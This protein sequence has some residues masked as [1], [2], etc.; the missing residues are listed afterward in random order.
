MKAPKSVLFDAHYL[1]T[2]GMP[3]HIYFIP[4]VIKQASYRHFNW[5]FYFYY[6][7][8]AYLSVLGRGSSLQRMVSQQLFRLQ[9]AEEQDL[10][11]ADRLG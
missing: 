5:C 8:T 4:E 10:C 6:W 11:V 1:H 3:M 7:V 2:E 9:I